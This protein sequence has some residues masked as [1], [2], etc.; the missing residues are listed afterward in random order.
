MKTIAN[1]CRNCLGW[2]VGLHGE[3]SYIL[4]EAYTEAINDLIPNETRRRRVDIDFVEKPTANSKESWG[5]KSP[6]PISLC[7]AH[8]ETL[9]SLRHYN[10]EQEGDYKQ[11]CV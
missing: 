8:D 10:G 6:V 11:A 5:H 4:S 9:N 3:K 1:S 7:V 2:V